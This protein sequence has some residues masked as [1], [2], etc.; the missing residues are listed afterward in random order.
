MEDGLQQKDEQATLKEKCVEGIHGA[1]G[2]MNGFMCN[3]K[4][5]DV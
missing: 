3:Y 2:F 4:C 1:N 5:H